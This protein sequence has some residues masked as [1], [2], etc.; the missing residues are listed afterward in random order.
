MNVK[1]KTPSKDGVAF[2]PLRVF[3]HFIKFFS[4]TDIP[5]LTTAPIAVNKIVFTISALLI[6][7]SKTNSVPPT[8]V[9]L[10]CV[11]SLIFLFRINQINYCF[12]FV[13]AV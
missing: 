4:S 12:S 3:H 1:N 2:Y 6:F 10:V 8:V 11:G 13:T 9:A 5:K 7:A